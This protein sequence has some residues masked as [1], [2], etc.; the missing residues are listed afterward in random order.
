MPIRFELEPVPPFRLDLTAWTL[1]RRP[2]NTIDRWDGYSYR[3]ALNLHSSVAEVEV[4]QT[5]PPDIPRLEVSVT[6][7]R[8]AS[9][10]RAEVVAALQRMLGLD[11]D[12]VDFYQR[13][14]AT[15]ELGQLARRFR[16]VKPP[17]FPSLF[18]CLA[19]AIACQQLT[20]TV[21]IVLLNRLSE[22]FGHVGP[23]APSHTFPDPGELATAGPG[24]VREL[25]F[26]TAKANALVELATRISEG[27]LDLETLAGA[28]DT[29][30]VAVLE[31]LRGIGRWSAEYTL[32]RGLGRVAVFPG[33]DV[34]ARN[35][36]QRLVGIDT[37]MNYEAVQ[38]AV[39]P[40]APYA[41]LVYFHL[42]LDRLDAAGCL[43]DPSNLTV[44]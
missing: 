27:K 7:N 37:G 25:G 14:E 31:G 11:I 10:V 42:L 33:D 20:L 18:E 43:A 23:G 44:L 4:H 2:N 39:S 36:L 6:M 8:A 34:G 9:D 32:L 22:R 26:S 19:N 35:N 41:G 3:R 1:R 17:R 30:A 29:A 28:T 38:H 16:G 5:G 15:P 21:G 13:A 40:W 24:P 12:L